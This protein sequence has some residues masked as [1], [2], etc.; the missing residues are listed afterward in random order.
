MGTFPPKDLLFALLHTQV[1][2]VLS[3]SWCGG[4]TAVEQS[5]CHRDAGSG[6][7]QGNALGP[8]FSYS[9]LNSFVTSQ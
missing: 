2:R 8:Y 7:S 1:E 5:V 6:H 3:F 4:G 9:I